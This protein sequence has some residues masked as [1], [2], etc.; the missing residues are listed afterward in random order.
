MV[1]NMENL[2]TFIAFMTFVAVM[3]G[4]P[5][6]GNLA[7]MAIGAQ[8]GVGAALRPILG[9]VLGAIGMNILIAHGLGAILSQEGPISLFLKLACM[10]YMLYLAWRI[11][12]MS[13]GEEKE[14]RPLTFLEGAMIHPLSP[15][16]WAM[17]VIGYSVYF[18]PSGSLMDEALIL[19]GGFAAGGLVF[20]TSWAFAGASIMK[21]LGRGRAF[22]IFTGSMAFLML[23]TTAWSLWLSA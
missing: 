9:A 15:K 21:W 23:A 20:H 16:T 6:P 13:K 3:T 11:V 17:G 4:T 7:F 1:A 14:A 22:H 10:A 19:A 5:G 2:S 8:I 12:T 18:Q